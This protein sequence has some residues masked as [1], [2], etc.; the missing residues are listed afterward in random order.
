ML[1]PAPIP[2]PSEPA[3]DA[4]LV[5][6]RRKTGIRVHDSTEP[7]WMVRRAGEDRDEARQ[8]DSPSI[9]LRRRGGP[10]PSADDRIRSG[11]MRPTRSP[12]HYAP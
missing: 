7:P 4:A 10:T 1:V 5:R 8:L 12:P 6:E 3:R 2:S 11:R 9:A